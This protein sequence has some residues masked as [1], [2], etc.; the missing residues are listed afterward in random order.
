VTAGLPALTVV[1]LI[2][3]GPVALAGPAAARADAA[4]SS[5]VPGVTGVTGVAF[6]PDGT[7]LASGYGDGTIRL[8]DVATGRQAGS[9]LQAGSA[10]NGVAFSPDGSL[11]ASADADGTVRLWNPVTGRPAGVT[12]VRSSHGRRRVCR[13]L[14]ARY[15]DAVRRGG[16]GPAG[17][18]AR[19]GHL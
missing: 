3:A 2:T 8:W 5:R 4:A 12:G 18:Q 6:S 15:H 16:G 14:P 19:P 13:A 10:V 1:A 7:L 17:R 11:L 9:A